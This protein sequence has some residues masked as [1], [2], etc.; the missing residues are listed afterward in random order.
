MDEI[1]AFQSVV[2]DDGDYQETM[3]GAQF[4]ALVEL[5]FERADQFSLL[6]RDWPGAKDGPLEQALR[7]YRLGEY[8]SYGR[9]SWFGHEAREKCYLYPANEETKAVLL[10]HITHLFG[11]DVEQP[12]WPPEKYKTCVELSEA[13]WDRIMERWDALEA[14]TGRPVGGEESAAIEKEE[15]REAKALWEEIFDEADFQSNLED[16]CFFRGDE[17]FFETVTHEYECRVHVLD[18]PFGERLRALGKWVDV[19]DRF[20]LPLGRLS[21]EDGL[22]WYA[23]GNA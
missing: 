1:L 21:G 4:R 8:F 20:H 2:W 11:R 16:P 6:R 22:V 18:R 14:A 13:A 15:L 5:C 9:L 12:G 19:S 23:A 17:M 10:A 7:P 3:K